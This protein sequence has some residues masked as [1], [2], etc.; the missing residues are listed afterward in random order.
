MA[1]SSSDGPIEIP[2]ELGPDPI[3]CESVGALFL[4]S[5]G[6]RLGKAVLQ[7]NLFTLAI[8]NGGFLPE[9]FPAAIDGS[10]LLQETVAATRTALRDWMRGW[11]TAA[12][13]WHVRV[14]NLTDADSF[15]DLLE[16]E[17][18]QLHVLLSVP[19][20][21]TWIR[22]IRTGANGA[23]RKRLARIIAQLEPNRPRRAPSDAELYT[24]W[25]KMRGLLKRAQ[26]IGW[27]HLPS[28]LPVLASLLKRL[29]ITTKL[30]HLTEP[31]IREHAY[32]AVGFHRQLSITTIKQRVG[33]ARRR[34]DDRERRCRAAVD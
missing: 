4:E 24:E 21:R 20:V 17:S 7:S 13:V 3:E 33:R 23:H 34:R 9:G 8:A 14:E 2:I 29:K 19:S 10:N 22:T 30:A 27:E 6:K 32:R 5:Q 25:Q 1:T 12:V 16:T 18:R 26:A 15:L 31:R 28:E 11:L